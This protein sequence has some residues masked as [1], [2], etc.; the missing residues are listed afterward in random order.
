MSRVSGLSGPPGSLQ[1]DRGGNIM[2]HF[3]FGTSSKAKPSLSNQSITIT[4]LGKQKVESFDGQGGLYRILSSLAEQGP[5]TIQEI[6]HDTGFPPDKI[7]YAIK[8][9]LIP[10]GLVTIPMANT[11]QDMGLPGQPF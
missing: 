5:S 9:M 4:P 3:S 7:K 6:A 11:P 8:N 10:R 1:S 2:V